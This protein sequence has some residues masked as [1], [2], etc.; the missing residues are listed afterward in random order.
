MRRTAA[1]I[2][3]GVHQDAGAAAVGTALGAAECAA[4]AAAAGAGGNRDKV[5]GSPLSIGDWR[6][7]LEIEKK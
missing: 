1:S 5:K 7:I 4:L 3:V 2:L 6:K